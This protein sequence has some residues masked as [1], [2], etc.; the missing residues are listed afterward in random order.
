MSYA[1]PASLRRRLV[2]VAQQVRASLD[3]GTPLPD[4]VLPKEERLRHGFWFLRFAEPALR[5]HARQVL[6]GR[7]FT[8]QCGSI[9]GELHVDNGSKPSD[10]RAFV[11]LPRLS[12]DPVEEWLRNTFG[13]FGAI[14]RVRLPRLKNNWDGG[15]GFV[16]F[17][18][19]EDAEIALTTLDGT[20][21]FVRGCNMYID[22]AIPRPL[23]EIPTH[24]QDP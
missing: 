4:I 22:F 10:L 9:S 11:N 15:L 16:H 12:P 18:R 5:E 2:G 3:E 1:D 8:S 21:S 20:P 6:H 23:T 24:S 13:E 17:A 19:A 7:P 14:D